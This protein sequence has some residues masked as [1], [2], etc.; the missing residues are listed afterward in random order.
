MAGQSS[1]DVLGRARRHAARLAA[2]RAEL[3]AWRDA[4][5]LRLGLVDE[6]AATV[7]VV[8]DYCESEPDDDPEPEG[9]S[10]TAGPATS[11]QAGAG[12]AAWGRQPDRN[13][14]GLTRVELARRMLDQGSPLAPR[15]IAEAFHGT[16]Q[17]SRT[18]IESVRRVLRKMAT[19]GEACVLPD[20]TYVAVG[21][22]HDKAPAAFS[23]APDAPGFDHVATEPATDT[24]VR[25]ST[26]TPRVISGM[27]AGPG[28]RDVQLADGVDGGRAPY[29]VSANTLL[30]L[31]ATSGRP[32][33]AREMAQALGRKPT[34]SQMES[35]RQIMRRC[36][37]RGQTILVERGLWAIAV[38]ASTGGRASS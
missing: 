14:Q 31:L 38:P 8:I 37:E 21:S 29:A 22:G 17:V 20:G 11:R 15:M 26:W 27:V 10:D 6:K 24:A 9:P 2:E 12:S 34:K 7:Q 32:M 16:D 28:A 35:I 36:V 18:Q 13:I 23:E 4:I 19:T 33:R 5:D 30:Q 25:A 3:L 1:H